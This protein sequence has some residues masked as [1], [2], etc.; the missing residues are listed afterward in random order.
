[1]NQHPS[2]GLFPAELH[3]R[4]ALDCDATAAALANEIAQTTCPIRR[5]R[6]E[7]KHAQKIRNSNFHRSLAKRPTLHLW[8]D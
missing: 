2:E 1:M 4:A 7:S 3:A 6:L 8:S 5:A